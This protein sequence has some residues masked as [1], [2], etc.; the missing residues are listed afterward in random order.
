MTVYSDIPCL[1]TYFIQLPWINLHSTNANNIDGTTTNNGNSNSL[2]VIIP[3]NI[4]IIGIIT[5]N[6]TFS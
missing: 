3:T 2:V 1:L 6:A 4:I 5:V